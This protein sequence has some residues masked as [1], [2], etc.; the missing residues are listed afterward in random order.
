LCNAGAMAL[1]G[2]HALALIKRI[3]DDNANREFYLTD[4]VALARAANLRVVVREA[5][6]EEVMG[7]ND[8]SQLA[9]AEV[10]MQARL[11]E[12]AITAGATLVAPE[13][14]HLATDTKLGRD[15]IVEP[16]VVFG[17]GVVVEEGATIRSFSHLEGTTVGA[18][19]TVG[20]F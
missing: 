16:Y 17:P 7:V 4:A 20:P 8:M 3:S 12:A 18:H 14:V 2:A 1:S 15:V 9:V 11:R 13:T 6:E 19:A 5:G 10:G